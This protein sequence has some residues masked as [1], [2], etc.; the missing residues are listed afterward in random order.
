MMRGTELGFMM[1]T[2]VCRKFVFSSMAANSDAALVNDNAIL[3]ITRCAPSLFQS[4]SQSLCVL[5]S[6]SPTPFDKDDAQR[7]RMQ[8]DY[9]RSGI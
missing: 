4:L 6:C 9:L 7:K 1:S 3:I 2:R 5:V 8:S